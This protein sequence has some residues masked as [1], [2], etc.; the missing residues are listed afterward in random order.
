MGGRLKGGHDGARMLSF[1]HPELAE[2]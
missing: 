2:V 1:P